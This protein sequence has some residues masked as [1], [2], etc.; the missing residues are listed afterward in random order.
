MRFSWTASLTAFIRDR[1]PQRYTPGLSALITFSITTLLDGRPQVTSKK[2][3]KLL[4]FIE[5]AS[6]SDD[7]DEDQHYHPQQGEE[8]IQYLLV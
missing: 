3:D 7:D 2:S 6:D 4:I 8:Q 1:G 5:S